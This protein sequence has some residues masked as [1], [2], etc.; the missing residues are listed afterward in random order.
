M[1]VAGMAG[2]SPWGFARGTSGTELAA[3]VASAR[4][5]VEQRPVERVAP[6]GGRRNDA[7]IS[8]GVNT[9][10]GLDVWAPLTD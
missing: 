5:A 8:G 3:A 2:G 1:G 4:G 7:A 6:R 9:R 10:P